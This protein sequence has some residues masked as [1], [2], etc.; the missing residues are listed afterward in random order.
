MLVFTSCAANYLP[1]ATVLAQSLKGQHPDWHFC[2]LLVD[3]L[4]ADLQAADNAFDRIMNFADLGIPDYRAWA[5][6]H[7]V[8]E[9]C[10]AVKGLALNR[11]LEQEAWDKVMYLDPDILVLASLAPLEHMLDEH[12]ILLTPHQLA[13][14]QT[15]QAIKD[16]EICSLTHGVFNLGFVAA[17]R[18]KD[19]I[20]FSR[21]WRDRLADW[22]YDDKPNGL[23]TDQKWCD[24]APAYFP[25]L[26]IVRD[27]GCNAASW[28]LTDR[29]ITRDAAGAYLANGQPLRFYHFTGHDSGM[30][31]LMSSIYGASMPAVA[32]LWRQYDKLL[33]KAGH[34]E[35]KKLPAGIAAYSNGEHITPEARAFYR[36]NSQIRA[37]FPDPFLTDSHGQTGFAAYW[38]KHQRRERNRIYVWA[39]KPF[40]L[41][42][43]TRIYLARNGG[44]AAVPGL[45][46][47]VRNA[48]RNG[49]LSGLLAAIKKFR[50]NTG[51]G[52]LT[53]EQT[54]RPPSQ[55][56]DRLGAAFGGSEGALVID[57][58]YGGGANSYRQKRIDQFL[59]A[60]K[61][62]LLLTWDFFGKRLKCSFRLPDGSGID[63]DGRSLSDLTAFP[64]IRL[65][66]ILINELVLWSTPDSRDHYAA[67]PQLLDVILNLRKRDSSFLEIA[68]NDYYAI[69]PNY[70]L[71][72]A[73][74]AF[75]QLPDDPN[76]CANCLA[77]SPFPVPA[78]FSIAA[79][80]SA[81]A[82]T[83]QS[84]DEVRVFSQS[85]ADIIGSV[86]PGTPVTVVPHEELGPLASPST[87]P[88]DAPLRIG[89]VGHITS[90][91]GAKIVRELAGLLA[92]D[93]SL[94]VLGE[95]EDNPGIQATGPYA[96]EELPGLIERE[97]ATVCL[98]PS[99][100]PETYCY[101]VQEIMQ[102][103]L[104]LAVFP[105]GAQAER[106]KSYAK[107]LVASGTSAKAGLDALRELNQRRKSDK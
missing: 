72:E 70:N 31:R 85:S 28:N 53:L 48:W 91:K 19:G 15:D 83:L 23:F 25:R 29:T 69:C 66:H 41:A 100:W 77:K 3:P 93:E 40:R 80:R 33:G 60:G 13:P 57:H 67:L 62:V 103:G 9:L 78:N 96:R 104:P 4:P 52:L 68:V 36:A 89:V 63:A 84:A 12:D 54:L 64:D 88:K 8:V 21:F 98:V 107:G 45:Y 49:G 94:V 50:Q 32:D 18:R 17:A 90:H 101:V 27:P 102:M 10:T 34:A 76:R 58:M 73:G 74:D 30:G 38:R 105:L 1:K 47:K 24:L 56:A 42:N 14:Q 61:P 55:W 82:R 5:F 44:L 2:L 86:Y 39:R 22:C 79:W 87:P 26:K 46:A 20:A 95:L 51:A 37:I 43:L 92:P 106:V 97:G 16:N 6:Q 99:I 75:C 7:N 81:W 11:F 65:G 71:L 35:Y 59:Q